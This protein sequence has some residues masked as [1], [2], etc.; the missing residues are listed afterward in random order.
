[1]EDLKNQTLS[2]LYPGKMAA[3]F[4]DFADGD[5]GSVENFT[6]IQL[7]TTSVWVRLHSEF[8]HSQYGHTL[9]AATAIGNVFYLDLVYPGQFYMNQFSLEKNI[10]VSVTQTIGNY[11]LIHKE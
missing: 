6:G 1:M 2:D 10:A 8:D 4:D 9:A 7:D 3:C 5:D 11:S